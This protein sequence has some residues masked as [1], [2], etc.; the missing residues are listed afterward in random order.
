MPFSR[1]VSHTV[2]VVMFA[3][4]L[5]YALFACVHVCTYILYIYSITWNICQI[6]FMKV[7]NPEPC[8]GLKVHPKNGCVP[9]GGVSDLQLCLCPESEALF[10]TEL[11]VAIRGG[12]RLSLKLVGAAEKPRVTIDRVSKMQYYNTVYNVND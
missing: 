2:Y 11:V 7:V 9:V 12:K 6:F 1:F 8:P 4:V 3:C 5:V 10:D